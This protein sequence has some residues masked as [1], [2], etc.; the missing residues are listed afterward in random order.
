MKL[1][2]DKKLKDMIADAQAKKK[3]EEGDEM[4]T[5][6]MAET[7]K[8]LADIMEET[9]SKIKQSKNEQERIDIC[10]G[11]RERI[12]RSQKKFGA[13][14]DIFHEAED[15]FVSEQGK[16]DAIV[17]QKDCDTY[18]DELMNQFEFRLDEALLGAGDNDDLADSDL[19]AIYHAFSLEVEGFAIEEDA[20]DGGI[21][22]QPGVVRNRLNNIMKLL[23]DHKSQTDGIRAKVVAACNVTFDENGYP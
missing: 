4:V 21:D 7:G 10:N 13:P 1:D 2:L 8:D 18:A 3:I 9:E 23:R 15:L 19:L 16:A 22:R 11:A 12:K 6:V 14:K 20:A 17:K 5:D